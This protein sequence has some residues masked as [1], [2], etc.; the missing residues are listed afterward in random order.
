MRRVQKIVTPPAS[1]PVT[2][3]EVKEH[4]RVTFTDHDDLIGIYLNSS[5]ALIEQI[6]QRKLITQTWKMF[7]DSWPTSIKVLFGDL[8]SV[9]HIKYTDI[10]E[11]QETFAGTNY[12]VDINSVPGRVVLKDSVVWPTVTLN[13]TNPIE[14]Q[15][16]SGYGD[17]ST[18][19]PPDIRGAILLTVAHF[20][21]TREH[22]L[23]SDIKLMTVEDIPWTTK[24]LLQNHRVWNWII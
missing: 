10:D 3:A 24:T 8:Q 16:V 6:L 5:V 21:E 15:F 20:Y 22:V 13:A 14:I 1:L 23:V 19:I 7:L 4:M 17:A 18:D 9:T 2:L 11:A 12:N